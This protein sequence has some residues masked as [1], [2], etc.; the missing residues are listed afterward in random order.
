MVRER[1]LQDCLR[2]NHRE[3]TTT[4]SMERRHVRLIKTSRKSVA[5]PHRSASGRPRKTMAFQLSSVFFM[6]PWA[7][8]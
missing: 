2:G 7:C 4:P 5:D 8:R 6:S 3:G 1:D